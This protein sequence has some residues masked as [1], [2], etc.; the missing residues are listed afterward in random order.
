MSHRIINTITISCVL[1]GSSTVMASQQPITVEKI[2]KE[3]QSYIVDYQDYPSARRS[4]LTKQL[5]ANVE[6]KE[7]PTFAKVMTAAK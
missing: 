7:K 3:Y 5:L 2:A 6:N 1:L 4:A